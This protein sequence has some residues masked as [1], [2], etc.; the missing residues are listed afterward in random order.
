MPIL[1]VLGGS[2]PPKLVMTNWIWFWLLMAFLGH[3]LEG[4]GISGYLLE[5][6]AHCIFG[7]GCYLFIGQMEG[8]GGLV[9]CSFLRGL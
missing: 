8:G 4:V 2:E 5:G 1:S 7:C 6:T 3:A 9:R